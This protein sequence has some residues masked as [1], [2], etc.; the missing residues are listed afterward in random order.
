[1]IDRHKALLL[2]IGLGACAHAEEQCEVTKK[3]PVWEKGVFVGFECPPD[4][5]D[6]KPAEDEDPR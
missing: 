5:P 3:R 2:A 6:A 4:T 1:M